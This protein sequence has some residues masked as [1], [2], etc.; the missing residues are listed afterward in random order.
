MTA[1]LSGETPSP[2]STREEL[3]RPSNRGQ[4]SSL[5]EYLVKLE[6]L[7]ISYM[8]TLRTI[9]LEKIRVTQIS[10]KLSVSFEFKFR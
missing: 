4:L 7:L 3:Y 6:D 8:A 9:L 1:Q 5:K 10:K 2:E